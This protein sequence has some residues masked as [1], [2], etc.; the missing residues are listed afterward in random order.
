MKGKFEDKLAQLAF[1]ELSPDAAA[2]LEQEVRKDPEALRALSVYKDMREG[3]RSL[4]DVP[5]DQF[6]KERLRDAILTQGLRPLPTRP[7]SNR[8]WLW[9]PAMACV[10]GFGLM[11]GQN[12]LR[13]PKATQVVIN[14][15]LPGIVTPKKSL[16]EA[17]VAI[18]RTASLLPAAPS[19]PLKNS[20]RELVAVNRDPNEADPKVLASTNPMNEDSYDPDLG[21]VPANG[22]VPVAGAMVVAN[23]AKTKQNPA[24]SV[25][26]VL[27]DQDTDEQTGACKATEVGS[28][29]NVLVGG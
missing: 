15:E 22:T 23:A 3:L 21:N 2:K 26:I 18:D 4:S 8:S 12:M 13:K 14:A 11:F 16:F 20:N 1:G 7:V 27:I 29:S 19:K 24:T 9:M 28:S 17:P 6:S 25:P 5:E 10:L